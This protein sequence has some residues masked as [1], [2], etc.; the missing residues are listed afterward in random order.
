MIDHIETPEIFVFSEDKRQ[1]YGVLRNTEEFTEDI[2]FNTCSEVHLKVAEK[3][4]DPDTGE[5]ITN[6]VYKYLEKNNLLYLCDDNEYFSFP[7]RTLKSDYGI[8]D[9]A[10]IETNYGRKVDTTANTKTTYEN[11]ESV[12]NGF[13]LQPETALYDICT[14]QGYNWESNAV[15]STSGLRI[16]TLDD[17]LPDYFNKLACR[18]YIPITSYDVVA[19]RTSN[20]SEA[21]DSNIKYTQV[22]IFFYTDSNADSCIGRLSIYNSSSHNTYANPVKRFSIN[23]LT[24]NDDIGFE[25]GDSG[26]SDEAKL[27]KFK[28]AFVNG[29]YIR[30]AILENYE[31]GSPKT[32]IG[33]S[34]DET[35]LRQYPSSYYKTNGGSV[36]CYNWSC[37]LS[38]WIQIY[39]GQRFCSKVENDI[40][41]GFHSVPLRWFVITEVEDEFD[42]NTRFKTISAFSYEYV[43]GNRTISL[44]EG[45]IPFYIPPSITNTVNGEDWIID[46]EY[47]KDGLTAT[48]ASQY[49]ASG[50]LNQI[51]E[52][53]PNWS[54]GHISSDLM[55]RYRK[56]DNVDNVNLYSFLLNDI[57]NLYQCYFVFDCDTQTISAYTQE[58]IINNSNILLN[59][60]NALKGLT[61]SDQDTNFVTALRV[62]TADDTYGVGL[63]NPT[64]NSTI[65]NFN[66]ILDKLDFVADTSNNDPLY[67][68][69]I[70]RN[71]EYVDYRTLKQAVMKFMNFISNPNITVNVPICTYIGSQDSDNSDFNSN[72]VY[73]D[74]DVVISGIDSYR[75]KAKIFVQVN[76]DKIKGESA[77]EQAKADYLAALDSFTVE[78]EYQNYSTYFDWETIPTPSQ[79]EFY[80]TANSNYYHLNDKKSLF[81]KLFNTSKKYYSAKST[82]EAKVNDYNSYLK[83]LQTV[84]KKSNLNYY[85]QLK[86]TEQYRNNNG[87]DDDGNAIVLSLLTPAEI[88]A[89]QPFIREGDWTN[90]NSVFSEDYDAKDIITTLVSTF[91]QADSDM[92]TFLS[93]PCYDFESSVV[94]WTTIPEMK[95]VYQ[96]LKLGQTLYINT[97]GNEYVIPLLLE[98]HLNYKDK[99]D[100][101]M[102]FTTDYKKKVAELRFYDLYSTVNQISTTDNTFTFNE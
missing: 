27:N 89:L 84:S 73:T 34:S 33:G 61:I 19:I 35:R 48:T 2:R 6:P 77:L 9:K 83:V 38:G 44:S 78:M 7:N 88:L 96:K 37:P 18:N 11:D 95:K 20:Y 5:W 16:R 65:Y 82:Y 22:N 101:T 80:R 50:L 39:S 24:T 46:K 94:N 75:D 81:K 76:L 42:G 51:L 36:T 8:L 100:F 47:G 1:N 25:I 23:S 40:T 17:N 14:S 90:D 92:K 74:T 30:V 99:E 53:L 56:I 28:K 13:E 31:T 57:E 52:V 97:I 79:L 12:L 66:S 91:N 71:G 54:V 69:R 98:L 32:I 41:N 63:V 55:T 43:L 29:G 4:C 15:L 21:S 62:H 59:W 86:L 49:M 64:G 87:L 67:R 85:N 93:K 60:Q 70:L 3:F 26:D 58:D 72:N 68:N 45:T 102:Q 10:D